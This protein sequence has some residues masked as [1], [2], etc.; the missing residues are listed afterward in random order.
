MHIILDIHF[1]PGGVN[2]MGF[3]EGE[4]RFGWFTNQTNLSTTRSKPSTLL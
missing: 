3:G 4:G 1:L 2:D